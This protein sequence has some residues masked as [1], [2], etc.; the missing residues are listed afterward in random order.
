MSRTLCGLFL[1]GLVVGGHR[2]TLA[3]EKEPEIARP[4]ITLTEAEKQAG[5]EFEGRLKAYLTLH[6]K[7]EAT[8]PKLSKE[9]TPEEID[10]NQRS[11]GDLIKAER[12]GAKPGEFFTPEMQS[13]IRRTM[14]AVC[15]GPGG[16]TIKASIMDENPGLPTLKVNDRYPDEVPLS[17]M[18]PQVLETLPKLEED[19]EYRFIGKRLVLLDTHAHLIVDYTGDVLP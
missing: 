14:E 4:L 10:K 17:T 16:K 3:K 19:L 13:L 6:R 7:A 2:E 1:A 9:S 8:L 12:T 18:P 5:V 15:A 11:L